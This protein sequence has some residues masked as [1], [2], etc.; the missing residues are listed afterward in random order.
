MLD[1]RSAQSLFHCNLDR[2]LTHLGDNQRLGNGIR[3]STVGCNRRAEILAVSSEVTPR[4][5]QD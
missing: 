1:A 3:G 5:L 2:I 4:T